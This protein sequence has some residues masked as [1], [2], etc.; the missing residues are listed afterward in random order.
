MVVD[1]GLFLVVSLFV[2]L[3]VV[4]AMSQQVVV[5]LVAM[6]VGP[7]VPLGQRI[8]PMVVR[9][10]VMVVA[11]GRGGMVMRGLLTFA[12]SPLYRHSPLLLA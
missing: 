12:F 8:T 1:V 2:F 5:V 9:D 3:A 6:P 7:M 11:V 10:M 4:V